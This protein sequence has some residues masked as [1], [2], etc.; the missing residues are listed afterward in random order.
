MYNMNRPPKDKD[1]KMDEF[2]TELKNNAIE[3]IEPKKKTGRIQYL[4]SLFANSTP[5]IEIL[6]KCTREG[7][8]RF[9]VPIKSMGVTYDTL[10][11]YHN[12]FCGNFIINFIGEMLVRDN[13]D[14]FSKCIFDLKDDYIATVNRWE[15][16]KFGLRLEKDKFII[17]FHINYLQSI[18]TEDLKRGIN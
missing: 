8:V 6:A 17:N 14:I 12:E 4:I 15:H 5:K 10:I 18:L 11:K 16:R 9:A 1:N 3:H 7:D 13:L 2:I